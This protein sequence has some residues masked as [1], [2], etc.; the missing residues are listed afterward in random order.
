VSPVVQWITTVG[1]GVATWVNVRAWRRWRR[2]AA[3]DHD[4]TRLASLTVA[5]LL[6]R[7]RGWWECD[8]CGGRLDTG[9]GPDAPVCLEYDDLDQ[10]TMIC[11][12]CAP[13]AGTGDVRLPVT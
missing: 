1:C 9:I 5:A 10:L 6:V 2:A 3:A 4:A 8:R 7:G 11:P 13:P 12:G